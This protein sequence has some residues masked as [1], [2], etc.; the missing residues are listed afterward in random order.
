MA[1][2]SSGVATGFD[3][4]TSRECVWDAQGPSVSSSFIH[5]RRDEWNLER[6][7]SFSYSWTDSGPAPTLRYEKPQDV[8]VRVTRAADSM[9]KSK[10]E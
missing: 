10:G 1:V 9:R 6:I 5:R 3:L 4:P 8:I 7:A 2:P